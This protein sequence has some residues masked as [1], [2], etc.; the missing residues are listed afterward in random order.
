MDPYYIA[1]FNVLTRRWEL[2]R[3]TRYDE[4]KR[5]PELVNSYANETA[6]KDAWQLIITAPTPS[7]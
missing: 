4:G 6:L 7:K 5:R 3:V 1:E 2:Y